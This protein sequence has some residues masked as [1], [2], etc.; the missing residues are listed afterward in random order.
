MPLTIHLS[1]DVDGRIALR[2]PYNARFVEQLKAAIAWDCRE[3]DGQRKCWLLSPLALDPLLVLCAREQIGVKDDRSQPGGESAEALSPYALMPEDLR[4]SFVT[5]YLA[6][7]APLCVAEASFRAL[8]K[9]F[10][11]DF[12]VGEEEV[13]QRLNAAIHI[14]RG[15]LGL[16]G[17]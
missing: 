17:A 4:A 12:F 7:N 11:P 3:W 15:Y 9:V 5:L 8:A 14:I 6:P 2:S 10:H 13:M 1:M 16:P